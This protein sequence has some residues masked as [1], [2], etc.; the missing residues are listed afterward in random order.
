MGQNQDIQKEKKDYSLLIITILAIIFVISLWLWV[1]FDYKDEKFDKRGTF[2]DMFGSVNAL[3]SGLAFVGIIMTIL[4][5]RK[6]LILQR[7]E[8][9]DTRVEFQVQNETLKIQRFENT[10][11]NL[12]S[13]HQQIVNSIDISYYKKKEKDTSEWEKAAFGIHHTNEDKE[14][15]TLVGRDVFAF[16]GSI[17]HEAIKLHP[18]NHDKIYQEH[19]SEYNSDFGHYFRTLYRIIKLVDETDFFY[20]TTKKSQKEIFEIK[21]KYTCIIRAQLSDYELVWLFYNCLSKYGSKF[22][23]LVEEYHLFNNLSQDV[24]SNSDHWNL[25]NENAFIRN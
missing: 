2:G 16:T 20:D 1:Y 22:K 6:E 15:V 9:K 7:Q 3:F 11:F 8:L 24:I 4:L 21:Y 25:Y 10:F 12:L 17:L 18:E 23:N 13:L 5:Q 14:K 19:Y